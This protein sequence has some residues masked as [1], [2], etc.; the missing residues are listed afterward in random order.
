MREWPQNVYLEIQIY[1]KRTETNKTKTSKYTELYSVQ[2][3]VCV[4]LN[5]SIS[6]SAKL[7]LEQ[8]LLK[9]LSLTW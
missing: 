6:L 8:S 9:I 2:L 7:C 3:C 5:M 4:E 1:R